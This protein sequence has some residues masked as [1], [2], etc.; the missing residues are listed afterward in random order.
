MP[1]PYMRRAWSIKKYQF[2]L[3]FGTRQ[4]TGRRLMCILGSQYAYW[5]AYNRALFYIWPLPAVQSRAVRRPSLGSQT[6]CK[7]TSGP[8]AEVARPPDLVI[9]TDL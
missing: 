7:F 8:V 6:T 4:A 5:H 1:L 3:Y 9:A 2:Y